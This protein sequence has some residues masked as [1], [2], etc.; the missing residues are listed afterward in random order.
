MSDDK[1]YT[2]VLHYVQDIDGEEIDLFW[3]CQAEDYLHAL[4]QLH[5]AE[6]N[7]LFLLSGAKEDQNERPS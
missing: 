3:R 5:N 6:D 2:Y 1:L 7:I 4:E